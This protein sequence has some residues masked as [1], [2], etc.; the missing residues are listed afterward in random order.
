MNGNVKCNS[1]LVLS[2]QIGQEFLEKE[3]SPT[4]FTT[5]CYRNK[6]CMSC[7]NLMAKIS[8]HSSELVSNQDPISVVTL[9]FSSSTVL[10]RQLSPLMEDAIRAVLSKAFSEDRLVLQDA[11]E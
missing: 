5:M 2:V 4:L 7:K 10:P 9:H 11:L 1:S 6:K 3:K 8:H